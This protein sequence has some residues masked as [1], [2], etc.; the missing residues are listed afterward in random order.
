MPGH[1]QQKTIGGV[2]K[3]RCCR[4]S[5]TLRH[6]FVTITRRRWPLPPWC[7]QRLQRLSW[8]T[9]G[10]NAVGK[11]CVTP[12]VLR[13]LPDQQ[14]TTITSHNVPMHPQAHKRSRLRE[15][16]L[17]VVARLVQNP[18]EGLC[19]QGLAISRVDV[20]ARRAAAAAT[21]VWRSRDLLL[22]LLSCSCVHGRLTASNYVSLASAFSRHAHDLTLTL[23]FW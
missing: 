3:T 21:G 9:P 14:K 4:R 1:V 17:R 23:T 18:R 5:T 15:P 6:L 11:M 7:S 12:E 10:S 2:L 19:R 20:L 22:F 16:S 8:L 13:S